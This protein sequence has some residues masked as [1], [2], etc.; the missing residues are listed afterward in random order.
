[1]GHGLKQV[2]PLLICFGQQSYSKAK[3]IMGLPTVCNSE[4]LES[5]SGV[6]N[7]GLRKDSCVDPDLDRLNPIFLILNFQ[8]IVTKCAFKNY[9]KNV[10]INVF[11]NHVTC[12]Q[13]VKCSFRSFFLHFFGPSFFLSFF[14]TFFLTSSCQ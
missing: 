2:G 3:K 4:L 6:G 10:F 7:L 8:K 14:L 1:M 12:F 11:S 5:R 9:E 13:Y